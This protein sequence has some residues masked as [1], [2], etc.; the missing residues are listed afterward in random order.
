M[1]L[2]NNLLKYGRRVL[3]QPRFAPASL[4]DTVTNPAS[5]AGLA[6]EA[7]QALGQLLP[8]TI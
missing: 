8:T 4:I 1:S 2:V 5:Y 3:P 6:D 7:T